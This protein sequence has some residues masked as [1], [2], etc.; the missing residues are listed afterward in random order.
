MFSKTPM[1]EKMMST[2]VSYA[3]SPL[4]M[5]VPPGIEFSTFSKL[6]SP[7]DMNVW[8]AVNCMMIVVIL[9]SSILK[10]QSKKVQDFVFGKQNRTP[11][12]NIVNVIVGSPMYKIPGRNFAR[13][14]LMMFVIMWL[15]FRTLYQAI[16]F[17][18][19]QIT[20]SNHPV[21]TVEE[22]LRMGFEYYMISPTQEN[23]KYLPEVYKRRIVISSRQ[24]ARIIKRLFSDPST[25]AAFLGALD[26]VRYANREKLYGF[27]LNVCPEP[28]LIRQY[29]VVF[30]RDSF[31]VSSFNDKLMVLMENGLIDYWLSEHTESI[32][33]PASSVREP[34]KLTN[35]HLESSY[36]VFW[37]GI[38][39]A[40]IA[41]I[42]ELISTRVR[43]LEKAFRINE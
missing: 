2:S 6:L 24:S 7:F 33:S 36:Q 8:H 37:F 32:K 22:S 5:V 26:T 29:G 11:F 27:T 17:Q 35:N 9:V 40:S 20:K 15:V 34:M 19:L 25:K 41:F 12:L 42:I 18:N 14:I 39:L 10:C 38:S 30:Q 23:I 16:L 43:L 21:Q 3:L 13:W 31:L 1:R 4:I 28:L